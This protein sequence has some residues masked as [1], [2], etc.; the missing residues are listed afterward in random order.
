MKM[1]VGDGW[2]VGTYC[3]VVLGAIAVARAQT[4]PSTPIN[5]ALTFNGDGVQ[6][7]DIHWPKGFHPEQADLLL[8]TKLLFTH[9]VRRSSP[10]WLMLRRG[11][12]GIRNPRMS[13]C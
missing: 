5:E 1:S 12:R 6:R 9:L 7:S 8:I 13:S 2:S 4:A 11:L 3:M 10:I